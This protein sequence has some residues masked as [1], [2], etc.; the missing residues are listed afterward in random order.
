M[1][2]FVQVKSLYRICIDNITDSLYKLADSSKCT[3]EVRKFLLL[4]LHAGIRQDLISDATRK[5]K[6]SSC[7]SVA[8]RKY[9]YNTYKLF[10]LLGLLLDYTIKILHPVDDDSNLWIDECLELFSRL[11]SC[12]AVGLEELSVRVRI[13]PR[14]D[15]EFVSVMNASFHRTLCGMQNLRILVLRSVCDNEVLRLLGA[16]CPKL[17]Q[18]DMTSSWLVDDKGIRQLLLRNPA[19]FREDDLSSSTRC[20][21]TRCCCSLKVVRIQDTNTTELGVVLLLLFVPQLRSLGGF[22]YYRNVGDAVVS[23]LNWNPGLA[24][25]LTDLW[26][27]LLPPDKANHL[28]AALPELRS[29]YTRGTYLPNLAAWQHLSALTIDFD[30]RDFGILLEDFLEIAG[31]RLKKLALVDQVHEVDLGTLCALCPVLQELSAKI[32][33]DSCEDVAPNTEGRGQLAQLSLAKVRLTTAEVLPALLASTPSLRTLE[34]SCDQDGTA[35]DFDDKTL[36]QALR[37]MICANDPPMLQTLAVRTES[38]LGWSGLMKLLE[39]C[40]NLQCV[41]D[42][43]HW[44]GLT[45]ADLEAFERMCVANNWDLSIIF[46]GCDFYQI[47]H[48]FPPT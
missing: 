29:L 13:N 3:D 32:G 31:H 25:R 47:G 18:L 7:V 35:P 12:H 8:N 11:E 24:L 43:Y 28:V 48:I 37:A 22:I 44:A 27:T 26:D 21:L 40:P 23:L 34:I 4:S 17:E 10:D 15:L 38:S 19:A 9:K 20:L 14:N 33:C 39:A 1:P 46:Q 42:L 41:G 6:C 5:Y 36:G 2:P 30:F 16:H 45:K